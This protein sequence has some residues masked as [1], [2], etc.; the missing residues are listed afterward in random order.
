[1]LMPEHVDKLN[2][3]VRLKYTHPFPATINHVCRIEI[4][5]ALVFKSSVDFFICDDYFLSSLFSKII[6]VLSTL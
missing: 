6:C 5:V 1:M 4:Q 2:S 3:L